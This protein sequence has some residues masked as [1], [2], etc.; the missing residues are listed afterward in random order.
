MTF[1]DIAPVCVA[2]ALFL[3][4]ASYWR[5]IRKTIRTKKSTQVSST[6]FLYKIAKAVFAM[7]GLAIY[8][9]F[10]GLGMEMFML[11]VYVV[12]LIVIIKFKPR[13]WR[14]LK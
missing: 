6:A 3:D 4:T 11:V 10:V 12:S 13:K 1:H 14:L 2:A 9:N 7:A 8:S 5:Q